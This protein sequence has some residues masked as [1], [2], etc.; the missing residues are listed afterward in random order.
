VNLTGGRLQDRPGRVP[1]PHHQR[2]RA[3][4][5]TW[6]TSSWTPRGPRRAP[7]D[8]ATVVRGHKERE[9]ITRVDGRESVE[10]AV[11]KEGGTN[12][13][14]RRP[15]AVNERLDA[16]RERLPGTGRRWSSRAHR[17]GALHPRSRSRRCGEM[18]CWAAAGRLVLFVLP[19]QFAVHRHHRLAIPLSVV[20]TFIL[21]YV[22]G[23]SLNI[24]SLGGLALGSACSSTTRSSCSRRSSAGATTGLGVDEACAPGRARWPGAWP[25]PDDDLRLRADRL[26]RRAWPG[27][28]SATRP[29][30]SPSR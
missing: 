27:S 8:V 10:I 29:S 19:A 1:R 13:L 21:M 23:V 17:P 12:T 4:S 18:P 16:V 3:T 30:R 25:H 2:D 7:A 11:Y 26:R 24:M 6:T 20:A 22:S 28:S 15:T 5:R 9:I 14:D